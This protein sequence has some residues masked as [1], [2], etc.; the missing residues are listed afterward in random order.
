MNSGQ[1]LLGATVTVDPPDSANWKQFVGKVR[2]VYVGGDRMRF[3]V[4]PD[5]HDHLYDVPAHACWLA[6]PKKSTDG[7]D[8]SGAMTA[9]AAL[10]IDYAMQKPAQEEGNEFQASLLAAAADWMRKSPMDHE[11]SFWLTDM[12]AG[13]HCEQCHHDACECPHHTGAELQ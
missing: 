3:V 5:D 1:S 7:D 6:D 13:G 11:R 4:K 9:I 12:C 2:S 10:A 8:P